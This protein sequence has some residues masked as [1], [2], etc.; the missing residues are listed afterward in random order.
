MKSIVA[1]RTREKKIEERRREKMQLRIASVIFFCMLGIYYVYD[2]FFG[3]LQF[4]GNRT[5]YFLVHGLP[6]AFGVLRVAWWIRSD[7][8]D[9][10]SSRGKF[11]NTLASL[12]LILILGLGTG[13]VFFLLPAQIIWDRVNLASAREQPQM[14]VGAKVTEFAYRKNP[15]IWVRAYGRLTKLPASRE[16][17]ADY[18]NENPAHYAASLTTRKGLLGTWIIDDWQLDSR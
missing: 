6:L 9:I 10:F 8:K 12:F 17:V 5:Y 13:L 15:G 4:G 11:Q 2:H 16:F 3:Y 7:F 14:V 18:K 1:K